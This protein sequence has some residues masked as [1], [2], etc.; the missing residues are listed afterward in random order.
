MSKSRPDIIASDGLPARDSGAW[1]QDKLTFL[2]EY[3]P[4]ALQATETKFERHYVDL[5]AGP[6]R[7]VD[8][9]GQLG[10]FEGGAIRAVKLRA[11]A[12]K[13]VS[14]THAHLVNLNEVHHKALRARMDDLSAS[15]G[16]RVP[17]R[18]TKHILGDANAHVPWILKEIDVRAYA[19]VFADI[20]A[21][22]QWPWRSVAELRA[23]GHDSLELCMLFPLDMALRRQASG[24]PDAVA[25]NAASLTRFYGTDAWHSIVDVP[26]TI[27][28]GPEVGRQLE[29][30]YL[31][32]LRTKWKYAGEVRDVRRVG[33]HKLYKL[34]FA[35]NHPAG[36]DIS[37]WGAKREAERHQLPLL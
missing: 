23:H 33:A 5:F 10:E 17:S 26:R 3:C 4:P 13:R 15:H 16:N 6:G 8:R 32:Q 35:T 9:T 11:P 36:R 14:F 2:D 31:E 18:N 12:G 7:N 24:S 34:L 37:K 30:L 21:P 25:Q 22:S 1:A 27:A 28:Q 19:F 29:E 20:E